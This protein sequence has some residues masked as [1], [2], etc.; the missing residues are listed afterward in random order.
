MEK[1]LTTEKENQ[2]TDIMTRLLAENI[3]AGASFE[4]A[5]DQVFSRMAKDYPTVLLAWIKNDKK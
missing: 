5:M 4:K 3:K 1:Y 2:I